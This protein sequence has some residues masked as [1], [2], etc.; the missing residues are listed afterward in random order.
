MVEAIFIAAALLA[1]T[2]VEIANKLRMSAR[3]VKQHVDNVADKPGT[4]NRTHTIAELVRN[5]M[6][7]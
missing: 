2:P 4:R 6:L 1:I 7:N 5:D 3:T